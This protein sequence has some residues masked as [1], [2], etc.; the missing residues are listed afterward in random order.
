MS[1]LS[2]LVDERRDSE[3]RHEDDGEGIGV[4]LV[5]EPKSDGGHLVTKKK[6]DTCICGTCRKMLWE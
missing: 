2:G 6:K 3:R 4:V 5:G 1:D